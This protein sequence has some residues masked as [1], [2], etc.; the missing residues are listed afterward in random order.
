MADDSI[1]LCHL[2]QAGQVMRQDIHLGSPLD[3]D[4]HPSRRCAC[5]QSRQ[6]ASRDVRGRLRPAKRQG[7]PLG[8]G[9]CLKHSAMHSR[10]K[11]CAGLLV[12]GRSYV[13]GR[14]GRLASDAY[15]ILPSSVPGG[16][17]LMQIRG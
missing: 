2:A 17:Y 1:G 8:G 4:Q 13:P 14:S 9:L 5:A 12:M 11:Q 7:T 16:E 3:L 15:G 6:S 10:S